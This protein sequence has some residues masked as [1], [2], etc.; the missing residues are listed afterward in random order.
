VTFHDSKCGLKSR[1]GK[2]LNEFEIAGPDRVFHRANARIQDN[3]VIVHSSLVANPIAVRFGW[4]ETANP[5]LTS[6]SGLPV[7]PFRTDN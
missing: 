3:E 2:I 1:D 4:H 6:G 5:N 7:S